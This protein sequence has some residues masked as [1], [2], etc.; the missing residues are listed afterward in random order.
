MP[1]GHF[2][3][4]MSRKYTGRRIHVAEGEQGGIKFVL[5]V[6]VSKTSRKEGKRDFK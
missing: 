2:A 6:L 4:A 1:P 3:Q 5:V